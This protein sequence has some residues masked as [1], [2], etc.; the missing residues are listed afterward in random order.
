MA[1]RIGLAPGMIFGVRA[2]QSVP[3]QTFSSG[4]F[5]STRA[6]LPTAVAAGGVF[7][8]SS[9]PVTRSSAK[10]EASPPTQYWTRLP[11]APAWVIEAASGVGMHAGGTSFTGT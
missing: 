6:P 2:L 8:R 11:S 1:A 7:I 5:V 4:S 10:H 3:V 9:L